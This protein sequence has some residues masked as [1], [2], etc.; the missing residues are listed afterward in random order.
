[1]AEWKK[2]IVSG[3][4]AELASITASYA[5][6]GGNLGIGTPTDTTYTD[7]FFDTFSATTKLSDA[8]DEISEAFLDLAP[9]KQAVLTS[10]NL[11]K[12]APTTFS[13]YLS[14][15]LI[16]TDWYVGTSAYS[17]ATTLTA[18]T[19]VALNTNGFRAGKNSNITASLEG[20][21]TASRGYGSSTVSAVNDRTLA[22]GNGTTGIL[23]VSNISKYNTFWASANASIADTISATGSV[24]YNIAAD[25]GAGVTNNYQLFYVGTTGNGY[26]NQTVGSYTV[27]LSNETY[28][29]LS[30]IQYYKTADISLAVVGNNLYNPVY[31]LNQAQFSSPYFTALNSGSNT[32][33]KDDTLTLTV[34][35]TLNANLS[36]GQVSGSSTI[37]LTKPGK[38]NVTANAVLGVKQIN[39]YTSPPA[40][41]DNNTQVEYFLDEAYRMTDL[42][43]TT[44]DSTAALVD[45][46]VEVQ[47]GR[48]ISAEYGN[49][50][51]N[52]IGGTAGGYSNYF[53][54][55]DPSSDNRQNGTFTITRNSNAFASTSPISAW[56]SGG[57]LEVALILSSDITGDTAAN[58]IYDLGRVVGN[59][60]GATKGI[61]S[62][63]TTNSATTY[64]VNWSLPSGINT[65]LA[66]A[67]YVAL[68]VRYNGTENSDYITQLNITYS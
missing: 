64:A 27:T 35:R 24:K 41:N 29:Y 23:T 49:Y 7:G 15:G 46:N 55:S 8:I 48:L 43:T 25:N 6:N 56:A 9:A 34:A 4:S 14:S 58:A 18:A 28:N 61:I 68:W 60:S 19:N 2:V 67:T 50:P 33:G 63:V 32:P 16:S 65:G 21:V 39:S 20:G 51:S 54:K 30:G 22:S 13:G 3:S 10:T 59:D 40:T 42:N 17:Q 52:T 36:S 31:N 12:T 11:T 53:R 66:S 45:G 26:P 5:G 37:T 38:S 1:M 44:W 47:N 62:S 57:E